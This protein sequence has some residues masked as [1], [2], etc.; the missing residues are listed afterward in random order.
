MQLYYSLK[1]QIMRFLLLWILLFVSSFCLAQSISSYVITSAGDAIMSD[2][3]ALY[4]S[5]GEPMNTELIN[6]EIMIS[7]G[8]LQVSIAGRVLSNEQLLTERISVFP[9][10][11]AHELRFTLEDDFNNYGYRIYDVSGQ[12]IQT[13]SA[14]D[15]PSVDVSSFQEGIYFLTL[16]KEGKSS[17]TIQFIKQ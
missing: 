13:S 11:T 7:Q 17:E 4:L 5:M 14:L 10:P 16:H 2:G 6:G 1:D 12:V 3:G 15:Q 9:N 8:F